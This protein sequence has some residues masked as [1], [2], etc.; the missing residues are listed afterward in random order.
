MIQDLFSH[1]SR[2]SEEIR[3]EALAG[4]RAPQVLGAVSALMIASGQ[5]YVDWY[6]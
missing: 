6:L 1:E 4:L 2:A 5:S 3:R